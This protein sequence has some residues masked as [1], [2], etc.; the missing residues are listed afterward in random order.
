MCASELKGLKFSTFYKYLLIYASE[1][2]HPLPLPRMTIMG[3]G[4]VTVVVEG[5]IICKY[6]SRGGLQD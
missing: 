2:S 3:L 5:K 1:R 4:I 6:T